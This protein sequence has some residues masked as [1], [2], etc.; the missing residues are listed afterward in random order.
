LAE[1]S[2]K[3]ED[4]RLTPIPEILQPRQ[5]RLFRFAAF[6][7]HLLFLRELLAFVVNQSGRNQTR[8]AIQKERRKIRDRKWVLLVTTNDEL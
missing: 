1:K 7:G 4:R 5:S 8:A 3:S 6:C 2:R